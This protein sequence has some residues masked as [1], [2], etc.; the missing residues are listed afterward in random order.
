M[1]KQKVIVLAVTVQGL[2]KA[3]AARRY[4]VSRQWVHELLTRYRTGGLDAV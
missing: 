1:S 2:S 3:E 4:G